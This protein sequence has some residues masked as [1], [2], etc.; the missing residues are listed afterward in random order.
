MAP[1]AMPQGGLLPDGP[2][3]PLTV[4]AA[5]SALL[6][7]VG[8]FLFGLD[9]GYIAPILECASFKRDVAKLPDPRMELDDATTGFIVGIFSLGCIF[10]SLP[11]IC[12]YFMDEWGRRD[13]IILGAGIFLI[14]CC[15]QAA[16]M[17]V[18]TMCIGRLVS[19]LSIGLLS[20][21]VSLYQ[22]EV[23]SPQ[24]RG[25]LTALYQL[26]ITFG[27]LIA[28][29]V[30]HDLVEIEDGWR[31]AILLQVIPGGLLVFGMPMLPRSPRWLAQQGR[32]EEALEALVRLRDCEKTA[33]EEFD[34]IVKSRDET[35][36][37]GKPRWEE[38]GQGILGRLIFIGIS[39]QVLQQLVGMNAFMYFGPRIFEMMG[40]SPIRYQVLMNL[41]NFIAT[42]PA[43]F[44]SDSFGRRI[45]LIAGAIVCTLSC[46]LLGFVGSGGLSDKMAVGI[47]PH[48]ATSFITIHSVFL[49]VAAF[50]AT[51]GPIVWTYCSEIFPQKHRSRC[52][53][54][55]TTANWVG[56]Y[57]IAQAT[58]VMFGL[59]G[60][61][62]FYV[63]GGFCILALGM[64]LWLPETK[65]VPLEHVDEVFKKHFL[66]TTDGFS[67]VDDVTK[68]LLRNPAE[69]KTVGT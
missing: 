54:I 17:S 67:E 57:I 43:I 10:T 19:G 18:T 45:L 7:A 3:P 68:P 39:L 9:I 35:R 31:W 36:A 52:M 28:S 38:M 64:A 50:A 63:F 12:G 69:Q 48:K 16:S 8:A 20:P 21:V 60:F 23:S 34:D 22:S 25:A 47:A 4:R 62:T 30:D 5:V 51:W 26:M 6:S 53:A 56:N 44:F 49:F 33:R 58:P 14:G 59:F 66:R 32:E 41:V 1:A 2:I 61:G 42:F 65:G 29:L 11:C 46:F 24:W 27:I 15:V 40:A 37:L 13:T 55:A